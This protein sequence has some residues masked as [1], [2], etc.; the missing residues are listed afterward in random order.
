M[1]QLHLRQ[2]GKDSRALE[3]E[4]G[5][6]GPRGGERDERA[7]R[8]REGQTGLEEEKGMNGPRGGE[9]DERASRRREGKTFFYIALS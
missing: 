2:A 4:K 3:E 5:T 8:R 6:N 1:R 7:S 9:R